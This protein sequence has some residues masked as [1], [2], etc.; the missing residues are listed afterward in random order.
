[1]WAQTHTD[2]NFISARIIRLW[3]WYDDDYISVWNAFEKKMNKFIRLHQSA[4]FARIASKSN[5]AK[6]SERMEVKK[7]VEMKNELL[8]ITP[9]DGINWKTLFKYGRIKHPLYTLYILCSVAKWIIILYEYLTIVSN[10]TSY[11]SCVA[12]T[13]LYIVAMLAVAKIYFLNSYIISKWHFCW[14]GSHCY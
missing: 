7:R 5:N 1:M 12:L 6:N 10:W 4:S 8:I 14:N 11:P 9:I 3:W 13:I 2:R